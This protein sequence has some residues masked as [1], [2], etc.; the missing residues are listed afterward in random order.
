VTFATVAGATLFLLG[1]WGLGLDANATLVTAALGVAASVSA[2]GA[3]DHPG[4]AVHALATRVADL[5]DALALVVGAI[6]VAAV[7]H[8]SAVEIARA[9]ALTVV[10]AG[11]CGLAGW[12]LFERA[13][14]DAERGV[15]VLGALAL[16]GGAADYLRCSPLLAG[17]L[18]GLMWTWLPGRADRIVRD[19]V[20]RFQ[21]PL[22]VLLLITGGA[23]MTFTPTALWLLAPFVVFRL[24][25]KV[26][27]ASLGARLVPPV[28]GGDLA[29]Y[30]LPPGL[31]GIALAI[32]FYQVSA[33][34]T[35]AAIVTAVAAGTLASEV[36]ALVAL[37][38]K[39]GD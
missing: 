22:V 20:S 25:G 34:P 6:V 13:R 39:S 9:L 18:A 38:G 36:L 3:P 31:M 37:P 11:L 35:A 2:A 15:F 19:D 32:N 30:L 7:H 29:A 28:R 5:D 23:L 12:L 33:T 26:I 16:V 10:I 17:M 24:A 14:S 27:G 8:T 21:H 1:R 4:D